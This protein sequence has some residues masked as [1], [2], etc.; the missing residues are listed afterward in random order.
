MKRIIEVTLIILLPITILLVV[1]VKWQSDKTSHY[2]D[3]GKIKLESK[4]RM[5]VDHSKFPE[6]QKDFSSPQ[7]VTE[8]CLKCHNNVHKQFIN[9]EHW[10]WVH[11]DSLPGRKGKYDLGKRDVLNNFCIGASSNEGLCAMCHA[12]YGYNRKTFNPKDTK[13]LDCLICH[14]NTGTYFKAN[15]C[16]DTSSQGFGYPAKNVNLSYVAQHV[17]FTGRDN[18]GRC[19]FTGGGGNNVKHGDLE[20]ALNKCTR[21]V[22][23]HM[24]TD[25]AN[26][27]CS[28]CH[29]TKNHQITGN[30]AMVSGTP[31]NSFSCTE[32]HTSRPHK[33]KILNDHFAQVSCEACHIPTYAKVQP[34]KIFWDWSKSGKL[35]K[36]KK[37]IIWE[38]EI[39]ADSLKNYIDNP[40][41]FLSLGADSFKIEY[42]ARHGF[43]VFAKQIKPEYVWYN[44]YTQH[45]LIDDTITTDT[46]HL[47]QAIGSYYDNLHPTDKNHPSKIY[48]VKIM[49]G[50]QIYD[51]EYKHLIN[52]RLAAKKKGLGAYWVEFDWAK[53]AQAGM[54]YRGDKFSGHYGFINTT[55]LWPLH[56][57]VSPA[58]EALSCEQCH[59]PNGRL[60]KIKDIYLPGRD[61]NPWI[62]Y[63]GLF[64]IAGALIGVFGHGLL[65]IISNKK[66]VA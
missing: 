65:R 23:V 42:D 29:K 35:D 13:N 19:H 47:S 41:Y 37:P 32:C 7:E 3:K 10:T 15:P 44:G 45:H 6:L 58:S 49:R 2:F 22:D 16:V 64:M 54:E 8:T 30:L 20:L 66:R 43:A 21:D 63:I 33:S 34:T 12:G 24:G 46:V 17:G 55:S 9:N 60:A 14:D 62:E 40:E 56:H 39:P 50:K 31:K 38:K 57:E 52:P 1:I 26:L 51:T 36:N 5:P 27:S 53:S 28:E 4:L 59:S 48:P 11:M 18:C 25:G 61:R